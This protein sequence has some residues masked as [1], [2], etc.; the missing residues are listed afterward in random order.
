MIDF[1]CHLDLYPDPKGVARAC[2]DR[3]LYVLSVTTTPSAW[4]GTSAL[5][6]QAPRI[7]TALGLHPQI[8]HQR[9]G[10]LPLFEKL[11]PNIPY[12]GEVGLDGTPEFKGH[13]SDQVSVFGRILDLCQDAGGRV[14]SLHTRRAAKQVLDMLESRPR[15]GT[16]ILHWFS[17]SKSEL[18]RAIDLG[19]WFSVG[20][21]M[22]R[23]SKGQE[24]TRR[25]PRDRILTESDGPFARI[26]DRAVWPWEADAAVRIL[27]DIWEQQ[28]SE[29]E[30]RLL[31]NLAEVGKRAGANLDVR[32]VEHQ[33]V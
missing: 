29:I 18:E 32:S 12:V 2:V 26:D 25:M 10:E 24:L 1:H 21:G 19:C 23:G 31:A 4:R 33:S 27:A 8:A 17:G 16:P 3:G 30:R 7:R 20:P 28:V 15:V 22:L 5:A 6:G 13:W 14:L 11:L 9:K